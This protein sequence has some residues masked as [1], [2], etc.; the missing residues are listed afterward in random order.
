VISCRRSVGLLLEYI[1]GELPA[2]QAEL[3]GQ[4]LA[5]CPRCL[6]FLRTYRQT[7]NLTRDL[8]PVPPPPHLLHRLRTAARETPAE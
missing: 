1:G 3:V 8:P 5:G 6:T 2:A 4:H 7:M